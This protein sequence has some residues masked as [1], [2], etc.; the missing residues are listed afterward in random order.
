MTQNSGS[1]A[2][3]TERTAVEQEQLISEITMLFEHR[4]SFNEFLGFQIV[5]LEPAPVQISFDMRPEL[6]GHFLYGRLHGGVISSVLDV[7]GGL[8]VMMGIANFHQRES[9][10]QIMQR[11]S[12]LATIDLRVDYLRQGIGRHF[13]AEARVL[14]LGRRVAVCQMQ[15]ANEE[16]TVIAT[17]NAA[18]MV[19]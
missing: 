15:L 1:T 8:G 19:S 7:V 14:R 11:F 2:A 13:I 16:N 18:Y 9:C 3:N 17:G 4:I 10:D 6:V 12:H 5:Q